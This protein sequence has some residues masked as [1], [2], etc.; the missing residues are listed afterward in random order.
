VPE[1]VV[2]ATVEAVDS[3]RAAAKPG[4]RQSGRTETTAPDPGRTKT[5]AADRSRPEARAAH[6]N[7]ATAKAAA[8]EAA[9]KTATAAETAAATTK[10]TAG[11]SRVRHQH[12]DRCGCEQGDHYCA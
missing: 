4:S 3:K 9:T 6:A 11:R 8:V 5:A 10:A 12:G 1:T 2:E 7:P